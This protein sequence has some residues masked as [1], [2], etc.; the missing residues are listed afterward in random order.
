MPMLDR[1]D[2]VI[3]LIAEVPEHLY[4]IALIVIGTL[5]GLSHLPHSTETA[6]S[7]TSSGLL[8]YKGKQS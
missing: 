5:I 8:L 6:A 7:L 2:K 3:K 1:A 4:A